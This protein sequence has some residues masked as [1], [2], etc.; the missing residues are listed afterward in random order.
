VR[1]FELASDRLQLL[2][3]G[4]LRLRVV[5]QAARVVE[6]DVPHRRRVG[7]HLEDLVHLLLVLDQDVRDLRVLQHEDHLGRDGVL[8]QGHRNAAERLRRRDRE[9]ELGPVR[10]DDGEVVAALETFGGEA[11]RDRANLVRSPSPRP[12]LP[13]AEVL[14]ADRGTTGTNPG[15]MQKQTRKGVERLFRHGLLLWNPSGRRR[16][17]ARFFLPSSASSRAGPGRSLCPRH[18]P[19]ATGPGARQGALRLPPR[20]S[21]SSQYV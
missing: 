13:D 8:V 19:L 15:V 5:T 14:L 21:R 17:R 2:D 10:A 18:T 11:E 7:Q 1:L 3:R 6:V 4:E 20:A 9:I 12:C 16:S